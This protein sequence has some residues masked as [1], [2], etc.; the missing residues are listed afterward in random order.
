VNSA[1]LFINLDR[2]DARRS[3]MR[4]AA[5]RLGLSFERVPAVDLRDVQQSPP[6]GFQPHRF[7]NPK[8]TLRA[9]EIAVFESHRAAWH[10]FLT[11]D[12]PLAVVMEDDLLFGA[13]FAEIVSALSE[14]SRLFDIVKINHSPGHRRMGPDRAGLP[15]LELR[16]IHQNVPDAGGYLLTRRAAESLLRQSRTYCNHLDDFVFSPDRG[17]RT[18]QLLPPACGQVIYRPE[19]A[20]AIERFNVSTRLDQPPPLDKGPVAYRV[21][22]E[23]RRLLKRTVWT[24]RSLL[25]GGRRIDMD[26]WLRQFEPLAL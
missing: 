4:R 14:H 12:R 19:A 22:K 11:G 20:A 8:W 10:A 5:S 2:D 1:F 16:P 17:L 25:A 24:G 15:G 26:S 3:G 7:G 9:F 18:M 6:S 23:S 21:L 13:G